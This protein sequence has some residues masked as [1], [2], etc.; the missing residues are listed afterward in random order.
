MAPARA[1]SP[2]ASAIKAHKPQPPLQPQ[3]SKVLTLWVHENTSTFANHDCVVNPEFLP[4]IRPRQVLRLTLSKSSQQQQQLASGSPAQTQHQKQQQQTQAQTERSPSLTEPIIVQV[5]EVDKSQIEKKLQISLHKDLADKLIWRSR[6]EVVVEPIDTAPVMLRHIELAFS[7]QY[8]GRSDMWRLQ[9]SLRGTCVYSEKKILYA[10]LIKATVKRLFSKDGMVTSGYV[11]SSTRAIFRSG[12]AKFF[13]FI[14]MSKE[15]WDFDEDGELYFEKV[16]N[17]FLPDLFNRWSSISTNHVVSIVLFSRVFYSATDDVGDDPSV[18]V[19]EDGR[20]YK[21]FYK[22]IADWETTENWMSYIGPLKREQLSFQRDILLRK[23]GGKTV[24]CGE[25]SLAYEGNVLEAINLALNPF[26]RHYIDRDLLR[27][28]LSIIMITPGAGK[29]ST[30]KKLLRLTNER[31]TDNGI[32]M[33]L[34]CLS[35][36][37]LHV[38][39]LFV[40]KSSPPPP[41]PPPEDA[42][43]G[44]DGTQASTKPAKVPNVSPGMHPPT[45]GVVTKQKTIALQDPLYYEDTDKERSNHYA[46][47]HWVDCSFFQHSTGRFVKAEKFTSRCKMY[48]IQM[49]GIMEHDMANISIPLIESENEKPQSEPDDE[50]SG[51]RFVNAAAANAISNLSSSLQKT[52]PLPRVDEHTVNSGSVK[53]ENYFP[54]SGPIVDPTPVPLEHKD[55]EPTDTNIPNEANQEIDFDVYDSLAFRQTGR[56]RFA[57]QLTTSSVSKVP[58]GQPLSGAR[59]DSMPPHS[60]SFDIDQTTHHIV[61]PRI[62][63]LGA[64]GSREMARASTIGVLPDDSNFD[65]NKTW[66]H[67]ENKKVTSILSTSHQGSTHI[68]F[69][70]PNKKDNESGIRAMDV[71]RASPKD[72]TMIRSGFPRS[73]YRR[74]AAA[75]QMTNAAQSSSFD[76]LP[77]DDDEPFTKGRSTVEPVPIKNGLYATSRSSTERRKSLT[78]QSGHS[79]RTGVLSTSVTSM[80]RNSG[81]SDLTKTNAINATTTSGNRPSPRT[82]TRSSYN[83]QSIEVNPCNPKEM[84]TIFTSHL[85]RWQ[86][87]VPKFDHNNSGPAVHWR[88]LVTPACLPLTTDYFPPPEELEN[89]Y[90]HYMYTVSA[91]EDVNLYQAGDRSM[92]EYKKT[93]NLLNEM[94]SQRLAQGFQIIVEG[95]ANMPVQKQMPIKG[96]V[97][98]NADPTASSASFITKDNKDMP[99]VSIS[100]STLAGLVKTNVNG[101]LVN[102]NQTKN[103]VSKSNVSYLSM[104]HQV[105]KLTFDSSGQNVEVRRYVRQIKYATDKTIYHCAI[106]PKHINGYGQ[107]TVTFN[108]PNLV[109][110]WNYLDH[111]V[112]GYQEELTDNLRFWRSRFIVVPMERLPANHNII[113]G[114]NDVLDDEEKRLAL[115][116]TWW[117]SLRKAKSLTPS[118][119]EDM[120]K[121]A[122]KEIG[123]EFSLCLT[124]MDPSAYIAKEAEKALKPIDVRGVTPTISSPNLN[125]E[126]KSKAIAD[127]MRDPVYGLRIYDRRWHFTMFRNAFVGSEFVDWLIRTFPDIDSREDAEKFGNSLMNRKPPL[128]V[129]SSNRH[130]FLDGHYF[131]RLQ[132]TFAMAQNN[133]W[134]TKTSPLKINTT[135][136]MSDSSSGDFDHHTANKTKLEF[137]MSR[138]II[139]DADTNQRTDRRETAILHYDTLHNPENCYHFQLNWLGCTSQLIQDLLHTWSRQAERCGLKLVEGSV[140]QAFE[141]SENENPFQTPVPIRLAVQPPPIDLLQSRV[142]V[143][144]QFYEIAL[145]RHLGFVLD[146]EADSKFDKAEKGGVEVKYSY[147]KTPYPYDQYIH[148][149]GVAFVQIRPRGDGFYW[150]NNRL[151][152]N[153]T[154]TLLSRVKREREFSATTGHQWSNANANS[155]SAMTHPDTLLR[156]FQDFCD[157]PVKLNEFWEST[158]RNLI[159]KNGLGWVYENAGQVD[160]IADGVDSDTATLEPSTPTVLGKTMTNE[161]VNSNNS[162]FVESPA[163]KGPDTD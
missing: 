152:T 104:G 133:A 126:S 151:F 44:K 9:Q 49:M 158:T 26:D 25:V 143:P 68:S 156:S 72:D 149:S 159:V 113:G 74:S 77:V 70:N 32:A 134:Y 162:Y 137:D 123:N 101:P 90:D 119:R 100:G 36:V 142:K 141:D 121:G 129:S 7:D 95:A 37:P 115:F 11:D 122:K 147:I 2:V 24:V 146:V 23:I 67:A 3:P 85:R 27:S 65:Y 12:S 117:Q 59:S 69:D 150:V 112:A 52:L 81:N 19:A 80:N 51:E 8:I 132:G 87:A 131:Y 114:A 50:P 144:D 55:S 30:S 118:E 153:H 40:F 92:P 111:L 79:P 18:N 97:A 154:T 127:A 61:D 86:H 105:H 39:P 46:V 109:Y 64:G 116:D 145:V 13:L 41:P 6:L 22:V 130:G 33:D 139:I 91:S 88:S 58:I 42:S 34:V 28:G 54:R 96:F 17:N 128:F 135:A 31:M 63:T 73:D 89:M 108:Y 5:A 75:L 60:S 35:Q 14:Q 124:T 43:N 160:T 110:A 47:P 106:W 103:A 1:A 57:R 98:S 83:K 120:Q 136:D 161:S 99:N 78:H 66:N 4:N 125:K 140:E 29:F 15:M 148:R 10:G 71:F 53:A 155:T 48:E 138:F 82:W 102:D 16:V 45:N 93:E 157:D 62:L 38:T 163:S 56:P 107:K 21:D 76:K 94:I 84:G 20:L